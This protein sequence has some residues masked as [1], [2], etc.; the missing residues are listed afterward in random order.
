MIEVHLVSN[1]EEF[2]EILEQ[3]RHR[4]SLIIMNS[5]E[6]ISRTKGQITTIFGYG[7]VNVSPYDASDIV[8]IRVSKSYIIVYDSEERDILMSQYHLLL[9]P[10]AGIYQVSL[11]EIQY[12]IIIKIVEIML[13]KTETADLNIYHMIIVAKYLILFSNQENSIKQAV[14]PLISQFAFL[15]SSD[16]TISH[17]VNYYA[18]KMAVNT[19]TLNRVFKEVTGTTPKQF[20]NYRLNSEAKKH[21]IDRKK[22]I[23]EIA[24]LIGFSSPEYFDIFFKNYNGL[25]PMAY[26]KSLSY[27]ITFLSQ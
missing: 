10:I 22:S 6:I 11:N 24:Y 25:T 16:I 20:L 7:V 15:V 19:R 27:N 3:S 5:D 21:L 23:K 26:I 12:S 4:F 8:P 1:Q 17:S 13:L 14:H 9:C 2:M 18:D